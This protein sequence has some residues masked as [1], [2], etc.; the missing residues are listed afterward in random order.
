M[1]TLLFTDD[2]GTEVS[3]YIN[4]DDK[5]VL[6]METEDE[7]L[8]YVFDDAPEIESLIDVLTQLKSGLESREVE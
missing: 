5:A 7:S 6:K 8:I 4:T 1:I 3:A 2:E